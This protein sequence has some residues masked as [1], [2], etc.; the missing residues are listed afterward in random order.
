MKTFIFGGYKITADGD[1]S[2]EIKGHLLPGRK[3]MTNLDRI[4]KSRYITLPAKVLLAY[5]YPSEGRQS[6]NHNHRKLTKLS[7]SKLQEMVKDREAWRAAVHGITKS[8]T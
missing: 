3:F 6:E 2:H 4:L 8:Q 1:C 7:L 5:P